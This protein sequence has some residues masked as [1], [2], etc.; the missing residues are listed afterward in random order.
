MEKAFREELKAGEDLAQLQAWQKSE[1]ER[2][3]GEGEGKG[4]RGKEEREDEVGEG[5]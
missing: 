1:E 4:E 3:K 5:R 2:G